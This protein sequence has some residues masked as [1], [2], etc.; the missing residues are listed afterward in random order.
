MPPT[1]TMVLKGFLLE[2]TF[3]TLTG[4]L[5]GG[6]LGVWL[7]YEL[8]AGSGAASAGITGLYVPWLTI[9]LVLLATGLLATVA[10]IGPSLRASRMAPAEAVRGVE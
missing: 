9:V 10:V 3:M 5:I 6:V 2:H 4:A 8:A 1:R 7:I